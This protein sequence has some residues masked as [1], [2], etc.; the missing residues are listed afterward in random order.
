MLITRA[1]R[2]TAH[3]IA[4]T[5]ASIGIDRE[6]V[7]TFATRSSAEGARPA[8]PIPLSTPA[9]ISPETKVPWPSA[10]TV[11]EPPT[12]LSASS[13]CPTSSGCLRS[14]PE[15]MTATGTDSKAG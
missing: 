11:G 7:T 15:S 14:A 10:S 8:M 2:S 5:S 9:A 12:K 3:R 1:P 6:G 4:R 13:H